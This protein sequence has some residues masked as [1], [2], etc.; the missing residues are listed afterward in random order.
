MTF[1]IVGSRDIFDYELISQVL[2][3]Y[4]IE[5]IVSGGASGVDTLAIDYAKA[6]RIPYTE[7]FA[8]WDNLDALPCVVKNNKQGKLYN[9][10]AG[11][12]RNQRIINDADFLIAFTH[13]SSGT[14]DSIEKARK[15]GIPIEIVW[16]DSCLKQGTK[17]VPLL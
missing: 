3:K 11:H 15:K 8:E 7:H 16:I 2:R 12:N 17:Q 6:N 4:N 1:G 13:G 14:R 9:A 10:L 5:H